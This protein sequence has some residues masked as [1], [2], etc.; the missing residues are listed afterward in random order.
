VLELELC[1]DSM[2]FHWESTCVFGQY[3]T[4]IVLS[5]IVNLI[6]CLA[7]PSLRGYG[8]DGASV[9][10]TFALQVVAKGEEKN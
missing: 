6:A 3:D 2:L 7:C 1:S 10:E 5:H 9:Y 8:R 4:V